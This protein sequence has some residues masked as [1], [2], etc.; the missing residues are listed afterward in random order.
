[1]LVSSLSTAHVLRMDSSEPELALEAK[2]L[3]Y[4]RAQRFEIYI[5]VESFFLQSPID[6]EGLS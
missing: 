6:P 3:M 4:F 5:R 2:S 1:M